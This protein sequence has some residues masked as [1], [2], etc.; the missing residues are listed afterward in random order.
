MPQ[1]MNGEACFNLPVRIRSRERP[2]AELE[3]RLDLIDRIA[4]LQGI[5]VAERGDEPVPCHVDVLV[6]LMP[7][8]QPSTILCSLSREG[9][10]IYGLD[11]WARYQVLARGWGG[12]NGNAALVYLPRDSRESE[13]VW[14]IVK[15]A[16]DNS[17]SGHS[18]NLGAEVNSNRAWPQYS[19]TSLQ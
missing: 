15:R 3:A 1:R 19:R 2:G 12:L 16:F 8:E 7:S 10:W 18:R 6:Q 11:Q 17:R 5:E 9:I 14:M 13:T 4:D